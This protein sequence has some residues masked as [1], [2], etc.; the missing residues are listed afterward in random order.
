MAAF[1]IGYWAA[2]ILSAT[3]PRYST[4]FARQLIFDCYRCGSAELGKKEFIAQALNELPALIGMRKISKVCALYHEAENPEDAGVTG[5][6]I[7]AESHIAIHTYPEKRLVK[8]D[9]VSCREFDV[10]AVEK[11]LTGI[12]KPAEMRKTTLPRGI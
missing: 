2:G 4:A 10:E 9:V 3:L 8:V 11:Y 5:F 7:I 6:V 1:Q 12:F